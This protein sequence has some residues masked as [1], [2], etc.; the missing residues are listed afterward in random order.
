MRWISIYDRPPYASETGKS[1]KRGRAQVITFNQAILNALESIEESNLPMS[2][3]DT[4]RT[5]SC[6]ISFNAHNMGNKTELEPL[7]AFNMLKKY[8]IIPEYFHN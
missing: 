5:H 2:S 4:S 1:W 8:E 3:K 7:F 6:I